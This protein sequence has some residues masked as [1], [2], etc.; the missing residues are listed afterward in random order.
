[1]PSYFRQLSVS[2]QEH[3]P[4]QGP[5]VVAATHRSRWDALVVPYA[6]GYPI[7]GRP[8][9]FM[10]SAD[11]MEGM[12]GWLIRNC[13]GFPWIRAVLPCN[14][15]AGELICSSKGKY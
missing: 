13:G 7:T 14:L 4:R 15:C 5:V 2:G 1:M 9:R 3:F 12:Q 8:L 11:E 10:V 6:I